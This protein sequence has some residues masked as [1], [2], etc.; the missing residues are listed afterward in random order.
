VYS[1]PVVK[2][3]EWDCRVPRHVTCPCGVRFSTVSRN[4]RYCPSCR[5]KRRTGNL[6]PISLRRVFR[7]KE[8]PPISVPESPAGFRPC[9]MGRIILTSPAHHRGQNARAR[10]VLEWPT[11]ALARP[12]RASR[13]PCKPY[14]ACRHRD[15]VHSRA[16]DRRRNSP[17]PRALAS[18]VP[19]R[20]V[21]ASARYGRPLR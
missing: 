14:S 18:Q 10:Q 7:A 9:G 8:H 6:P 20:C 16:Y 3:S 17:D 11:W 1:V 21:R 4:A 13:V 19:K 12:G 5:E 2:S 15:A